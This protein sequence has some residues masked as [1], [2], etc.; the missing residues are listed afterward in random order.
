MNKILLTVLI[1]GTI[2]IMIASAGAGQYQV[3]GNSPAIASSSG[4]TSQHVSIYSTFSGKNEE[5]YVPVNS[6]GILVYPDWHIWLYGSGSFTFSSNGTTIETGVSLGTFDF[7]YTFPG[8][9]G[10][11]TNASL[12]FQGVTYTFSDTI[13]GPLSH[14]VIESVSVSSSYPGQDQFLSVSSGVS[15]ALMYPHWIATLQSSENE[16]YS[17]LVNGQQIASGTVVG[18]K[19]VDFNVTGNVTSVSIGLGTHVYKYPD[20]TI[21]TVPIQKYYGPKPPTLQYTFAEYEYGII[22][23]F[24]ASLFAILI[25]LFTAKKYLIEKER[26]EVLRI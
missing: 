16:T 22:K 5:L 3:P 12:V 19:T 6:S 18:T 26:R 1:L 7:S 24:V 8:P 25:A 2:T 4:S 23:A 13:I 14:H 10:S 17:I 11:T 9:S 20:E 15:G 21:A